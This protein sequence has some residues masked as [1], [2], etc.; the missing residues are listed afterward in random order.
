MSAYKMHMSAQHSYSYAPQDYA[1][2]YLCYIKLMRHW[3]TQFPHRIWPLQYE[4]L[5]AN[6]EVEIRAL[7]S[8]VGVEWDGNCLRP[9]QNTSRVATPS[10]AQVRRPINAASVGRWRDYG[11]RLQVIVDRL[12]GE[13]MEDSFRAARFQAST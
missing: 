8:F 5:V 6:P 2:F 11:D 7:L 3:Y 10:L 12:G 9:E 13:L 4:S 1:E